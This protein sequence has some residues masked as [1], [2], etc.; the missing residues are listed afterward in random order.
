MDFA[1]FTVIAIPLYFLPTILSMESKHSRA[2]L[3]LN[4]LLGWSVVG[5]V[6]ALIWAMLDKKA[7][8]FRSAM[9]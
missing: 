1:L 8:P 4:L 2:I 7:I 9:D 6:A 3:L 5:W